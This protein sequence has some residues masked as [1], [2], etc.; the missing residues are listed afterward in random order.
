MN[1]VAQ[2]AG[3]KAAKNPSYLAFHY[4]ADHQIG[5]KVP[6]GGSDCAKCEYVSEDEKKCSNKYFIRWNG[7]KFLPEKANEF[8]CDFF[9]TRDTGD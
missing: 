6:K 5:M 9:E 4:P 1:T 2:L 7:S 8:C 3:A